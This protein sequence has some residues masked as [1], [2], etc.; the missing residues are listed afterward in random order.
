MLL[1]SPRAYETH[2]VGLVLELK[3]SL[4]PVQISLLE[5]H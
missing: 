1:C 2:M 4:G 5:I 3:K